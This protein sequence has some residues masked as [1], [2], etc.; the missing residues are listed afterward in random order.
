MSSR[1]LKLPPLIIVAGL[2]QL[3]DG[4]QV[5]G[6]GSLRGMSDVKVPTFITFAAY[7]VMAIPLS[8]IF[9][10]VLDYGPQGIWYGLLVG[11]TIAAVALFLRFKKLA[12]QKS[13]EFTLADVT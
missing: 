9:G 5:V 10:F 6:L 4:A 1:L 13:Q 3:S 11:L 12:I 2:F 8:Y 7:W